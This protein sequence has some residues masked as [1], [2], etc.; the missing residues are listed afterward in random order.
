MYMSRLGRRDRSRH[1]TRL[2]RACKSLLFI[3]HNEL[4]VV[5]RLAIF[6]LRQAQCGFELHMGR[7]IAS[8]SP[9]APEPIVPALFNAMLLLVSLRRYFCSRH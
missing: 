5:S 8:L 7:V 3:L 9:R 4:N 1:R 6:V 2:P